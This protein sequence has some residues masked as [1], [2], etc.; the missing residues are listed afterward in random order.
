MARG[1]RLTTRMAHPAC[2]MAKLTCSRR[3]AADSRAARSVPAHQA[4]AA[5]AARA[6]REV[7]L[8]FASAPRR[9]RRQPA[10]PRSSR[11]G[12]IAMAAAKLTANAVLARWLPDMGPTESCRAEVRDGCAP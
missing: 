9:N 1:V 12:R 8:V 7:A 11:V 3:P 2:P 10:R 5:R 4:R 6:A